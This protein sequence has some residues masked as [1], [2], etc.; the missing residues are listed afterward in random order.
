MSNVFAV[1][2]GG[3]VVNVIVAPPD[4]SIPGAVL[5]PV[6]QYRPQIGDRFASGKFITASGPEGT[7]E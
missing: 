2:Q 6:G 4:F 3:E 1:V 5:V 7:P